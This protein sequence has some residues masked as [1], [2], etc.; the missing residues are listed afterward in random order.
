MVLADASTIS[1]A[2][3]DTDANGLARFDLDGFGQGARFVLK[4]KPFTHWLTSGEFDAPQWY[5]WRV[6]QLS[7][8]VVDGRSGL[9]VMRETIE[10]REPMADGGHV[11]VMEGETDGDGWLRLDPPGFGEREMVLRGRSPTDGEW[12]YSSNVI[13]S[14]PRTFVLGNTATVASV[15]DGANGA[16]IPRIDV[17]AWE[18]MPNGQRKLRATRTTNLAGEARFDLDGVGDGREYFFRTAPYGHIVETDPIGGSGVHEILAG[19]LQVTLE[20]GGN[21]EVLHFYDVDLLE[22][23]ANGSRSLAQHLR[24]DGLGQIKIDPAALGTSEYVLRAASPTDGS[25]KFSETYVQAGSYHFVVGNAALIVKLIDAATGAGIANIPVYADEVLT[26][27]STVKRAHRDTDANGGARNVI[28]V[29]PSA[30]AR[31]RAR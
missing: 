28:R 29:C 24:T 30:F 12:K 22:A 6:G 17:E 20:H 5:E 10:V 14:A 31:R 1:V 4:S 25:A 13:G 23:H 8:R 2:R 3:R 19:S 16:A 27:G 21:G 26:D 7:I 11:G 18:N 15:R 9:P